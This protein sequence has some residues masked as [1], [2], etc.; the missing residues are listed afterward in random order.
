MGTI[1][2]MASWLFFEA[3][4]RVTASIAGM[5]QPI[6]TIYSLVFL[7]CL[8]HEKIDIFKIVAI[9]ISIFGVFTMFEFQNIFTGEAMGLYTHKKK[10]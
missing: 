2:A 3:L 5:F 8:G 9:I 6:V 7:L 4:S 10:P 1:L